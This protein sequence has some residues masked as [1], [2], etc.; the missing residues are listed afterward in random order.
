MGGA[1]DGSTV[2]FDEPFWIDV[3]E[4]T[5]GQY[6]SVGCV[7]FSSGSSQPRTCVN[8]Y[9]AQ[10][11]CAGR[12]G[13]L[14]T[15]AEWEYAARGPSGWEFPW[16]DTFDGSRVVYNG[17]RCEGHGICA[18]GSR[19]AGA[20]WVG[21]LDLSG[22]VWEWAGSDYDASFKSLRGGC[23]DDVVS[24]LR[25]ALHNGFDPSL[26]VGSVGFRCALSWQP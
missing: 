7:D 3:Y 12:G 4:V 8:W 11:H 5:N 9:D 26:A 25:P 16:G 21:A 23:M 17:S 22:N 20:S 18:V 6:G 10:T 24:Y 2:C 1:T 19:P 13:R 14:P 15:A